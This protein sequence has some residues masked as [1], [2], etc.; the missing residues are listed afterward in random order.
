[1]MLPLILWTIR[2]LTFAHRSSSVNLTR[3]R[4][5]MVCATSKD[6]DHA[7]CQPLASTVAL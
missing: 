5:A 3:F 1:L 2:S 4:F 6:Y 7:F